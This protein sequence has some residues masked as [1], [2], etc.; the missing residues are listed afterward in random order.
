[1]MWRDIYMVALEKLAS[2]VADRVTPQCY[3]QLVKSHRATP[4][5]FI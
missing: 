2:D 4:L 5:A 1:M 3:A